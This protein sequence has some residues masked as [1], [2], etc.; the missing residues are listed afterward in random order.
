MWHPCEINRLSG[1]FEKAENISPKRMDDMR[2]PT[3]LWL[4]LLAGCAADS[5]HETD[6]NTSADPSHEQ[7]ASTGGP[8]PT[9]LANL[10]ATFPDGVDQVVHRAGEIEWG[11][12]PPGPL[13]ELGC[14]MAV[15][16]GSPKAEQ[17]FTIRI[18]T[19]EPFVLLPHTHPRNERATVLDGAVNVGFGDVV[20]KSASTRFEAGDYYVNRAGAH[21]F[22]WSDEPVMIRLT[23][24]G[25]WAIHPVNAE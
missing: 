1:L 7:V 10:E 24:I 2:I 14:R 16:E 21:H 12:C 18:Q 5:S 22:V 9:D 6:G 17:V 13:S 11:P 23:G 19:T 20:D 3:I 15:L 25:P 4:V 8:E